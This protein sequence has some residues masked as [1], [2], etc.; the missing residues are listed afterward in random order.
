[1]NHVPLNRIIA[2]PGIAG[3]AHR[4]RNKMLAGSRKIGF[5]GKAVIKE[6]APRQ[7]TPKSLRDQ[8][9]AVDGVRNVEIALRAMAEIAQSDCD[10]LRIGHPALVD[11]SNNFFERN[12][13][14]AC[15]FYLYIVDRQIAV[16]I[17]PR[18]AAKP[19][20]H[21]RPQGIGN[22][23]DHASLPGRIGKALLRPFDGVDR[24]P[25]HT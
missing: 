6:T 10:R 2:R 16:L 11:W 25:A 14:A 18:Y 15:F 24:R 19:D 7:C 20:S 3:H 17:F 12:V 13:A 9:T 1:M 8:R 5:R 4:S 21:V 23:V 22:H